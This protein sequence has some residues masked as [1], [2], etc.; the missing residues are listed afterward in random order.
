MKDHRQLVTGEVRVPN[1]VMETLTNSLPLPQAAVKR[2]HKGNGNLVICLHWINH[3]ATCCHLSM[4]LH[5]FTRLSVRSSC[6]LSYLPSSPTS[7]PLLPP[8]PFYSSTALREYLGRNTSVQPLGDCLMHCISNAV[9]GVWPTQIHW[10][11]IQMLWLQ[12]IQQSLGN[13][14]TAFITLCIGF[15]Y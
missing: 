1:Q 4:S 10:R 11:R 5:L 12:V 9:S 7:S 3:N 14:N 15:T 6:T 2:C 13:Y 8:P